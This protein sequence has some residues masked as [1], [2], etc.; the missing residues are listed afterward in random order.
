MKL[1]SCPQWWFSSFSLQPTISVT[2]QTGRLVSLCNQ[3]FLG[4]SS[5]TKELGRHRSVPGYFTSISS[6]C[7]ATVTEGCV[8]RHPVGRL[9]NRLVKGI[10][11][12]KTS[13]PTNFSPSI[14]CNRETSV[15]GEPVVSTGFE[16]GFLQVRMGIADFS[17]TG[18]TPELAT[19]RNRQ[20]SGTSRSAVLTGLVHCSSLLASNGGNSRFL[21]NR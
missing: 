19:L 1:P 2:S 8:S 13:C 9:C 12:K 10:F 3:S 14:L 18:N 7:E 17:G 11:L 15:T 21:C 6:S 16:A 4:E 20:H 5:V